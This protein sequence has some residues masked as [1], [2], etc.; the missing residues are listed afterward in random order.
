[1]LANEVNR[2]PTP[3]LSGV[4]LYRRNVV[5][6]DPN[7]LKIKNAYTDDLIEKN[8]QLRNKITSILANKV[9]L[10]ITEARQIFVDSLK[11]PLSIP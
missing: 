1:M 2:D 9:R 11:N 6:S 8:K 7:D 10:D 5:L 3:Q 4:V